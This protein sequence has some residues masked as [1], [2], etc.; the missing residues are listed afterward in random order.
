MGERG[1]LGLWLGRLLGWCMG[2]TVSD[3]LLGGIVVVRELM[4]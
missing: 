1:S 2:I 3:R 4:R